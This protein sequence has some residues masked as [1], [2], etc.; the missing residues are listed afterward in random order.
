[1]PTYPNAT[2]LSTTH[3]VQINTV[4]LMDV[5]LADGSRPNRFEIMERTHVFDANLQKEQLS[6]YERNSKNK[7]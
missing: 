3:H 5:P 1:M 7:S 4:N 2:Q 6:K